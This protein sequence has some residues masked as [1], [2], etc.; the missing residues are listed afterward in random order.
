MLFI[1]LMQ[2]CLSSYIV[3]FL[4]NDQQ[5]YGNPLFLIDL[6]VDFSYLFEILAQFQICYYHHGELRTNRSEIVLNYMISRL[7]F[8][9]LTEMSLIGR[10]LPNSKWKVL[11]LLTIL[12]LYKVP[13]LISTLEDYFQFSKEI[14]SMI[15]VLRLTLIICL[16]AHFCACIF[17]TLTGWDPD[18]FSWIVKAD[19]EGSTEVEIYVASVYWSVTVMATVGFGDIAPTTLLE[20]VFSIVIMVISSILFGYILSTIGNLLLELESF[21]S[22][23]KEKIRTFTKYMNEKGLNKNVQSKIRKYLEFYL[24]KENTARIESDGIMKIL[25]QNLQEELVR[26]INAKIMSDTYMF[27]TNFR[28]SFL[29]TVSKDLVERSFGPEETIYNVIYIYLA[30]QKLTF[31]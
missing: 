23:A 10:F 21:S 8:D 17:Y 30:S 9:L 28:K 16:F 24:N 26:E 1:I 25:S 13:N 11:M 6:I 3:F 29:Y 31:V 19:L 27:C 20:R 12:R 15:R 5:R 22:E 2:S 4:P 14:S 7:P 18:K